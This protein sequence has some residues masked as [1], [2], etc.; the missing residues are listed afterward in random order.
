MK[1][2]EKKEYDRK[3]YEKNAKR[4]RLYQSNYRKQHPDRAKMWHDKNPNNIKKW[5]NE[6]K[7]NPNSTASATY[8]SWY[9][10]LQRCYNSSNKA[11]KN[12]GGRGIKICAR[13]KNNYQNF[14]DDMGI[15]TEGTSLD[16][17]DNNS[18]YS[19]ENCRWATSREQNRNNRSNK[20]ITEYGV[21]LCITEWAET[22]EVP[23]KRIESRMHLGWSDHEALFV[24]RIR[25]YRKKPSKFFTIKKMKDKE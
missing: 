6:N 11:Y 4:L 14:L 25:K 21:T 7:D 13:W 16:R 1:P 17:I 9:N 23:R 10:M 3:Y 5:R 2:D 24:P 15:M 22:L 12:Y 19:K 8:S 20:L 18:G